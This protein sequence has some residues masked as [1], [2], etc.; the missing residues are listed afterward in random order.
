MI[1]DHCKLQIQTY[2]VSLGKHTYT[3]RD[4]SVKGAAATALKNYH[5]RELGYVVGIK[6]RGKEEVWW[7]IREALKLAGISFGSA[8]KGEKE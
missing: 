2:R 1:C 3:V 6:E 5:P 8:A 4:T 7:D